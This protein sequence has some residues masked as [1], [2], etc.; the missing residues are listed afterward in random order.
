M[1]GIVFG[2]RHLPEYS[3]ELA[4]PSS[5]WHGQAVVACLFLLAFYSHSA[6]AARFMLNGFEAE[7][8]GATIADRTV[9]GTF[10]DTDPASAPS[11]VKCNVPSP[12][13]T[14]YVEWSVPAAAG[15]VGASPELPSALALV[16]GTTYYL[17]GFFR[18]QRVGG[19]DIWHD[20]GSTPYSFD[21]LIE[22]RGS[23]FRWGIGAGWNGWYTTGVDH[24]FVFDAWYA[25]S[26]I[27]NQGPDHIVANVAPFGPSNPL[28]SNYETWNAVV[29]GVTV[30]NSTSGRVQL[31]VNG[32]KVVDKNQ[33]TANAGATVTHLILTGTVAQP[34]YDAPAHI[35]QMDGIMLT[36]NWQDVVAGGY[37]TVPGGTPPLP[38]PTSARIITP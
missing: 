16:P 9:D 18:F 21:K 19:T 8:C 34:A 6:D 31:W 14:K 28:V 36:D 10:W 37:T 20:S 17:A 4:R 32:T 29:L 30:R 27:G 23:G 7:S 3:G 13:G 38:A 15:W 2:T 25:S 24:R 1:R 33:Y 35:R 5:K 22:F 11:V 26:V 12:S